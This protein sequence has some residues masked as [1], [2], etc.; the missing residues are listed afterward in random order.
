MEVNDEKVELLSTANTGDSQSLGDA[1]PRIEKDKHDELPGL[2]E[3]SYS[4][5]C[6]YSGSG[7]NSSSGAY[8]SSSAAAVEVVRKKKVV[9]P[10]M[11]S[12]HTCSQPRYFIVTEVHYQYT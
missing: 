11:V 5:S 9:H 10:M 7:T 3:S 2:D 8:S 4:G 1:L 6:G 12:V